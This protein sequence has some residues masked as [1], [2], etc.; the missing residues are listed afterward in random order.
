MRI[1]IVNKNKNNFYLLYFRSTSEPF[2]I[3]VQ[4][5][6]N[7]YFPENFYIKIQQNNIQAKFVTF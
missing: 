7:S 1:V 2:F 3:E 4:L 5:S 6:K